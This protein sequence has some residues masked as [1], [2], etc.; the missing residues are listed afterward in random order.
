MAQVKSVEKLL[1]KLRK[2]KRQQSIQQAREEPLR[3]EVDDVNCYPEVEV[4]LVG[5][6]QIDNVEFMSNSNKGKNPCD[7]SLDMDT[8]VEKEDNEED[9][10]INVIFLSC[11]YENEAQ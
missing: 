5:D 7:E 2:K 6:V 3:V 4:S 10:S 11:E 1:R 8:C 9:S